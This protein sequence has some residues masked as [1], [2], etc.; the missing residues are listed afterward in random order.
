M[1]GQDSNA[2]VDIMPKREETEIGGRAGLSY[3]KI[4]RAHR[5]SVNPG[6]VWP[7]VE[8]EIISDHG[9]RTATSST[10][11]RATGGPS[12]EGFRF[13][14]RQMAKGCWSTLV[15]AGVAPIAAA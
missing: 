7:H 6:A 4:D 9:G 1:Y 8:M 10:S 13:C 3:V 5:A 12:H 15:G 14:C 11:G 2:C